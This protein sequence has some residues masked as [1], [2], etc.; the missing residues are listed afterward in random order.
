MVNQLA[1][2]N[3]FPNNNDPDATC[4]SWKLGKILNTRCNGKVDASTD[5]Y[6]GTTDLG[7]ITF[8]PSYTADDFHRG[9]L[10][11]TRPIHTSFGNILCIFPFRYLILTS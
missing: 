4:V 2:D 5:Y 1:W 6:S 10:C 3:G 11:E 9:Y 8:S 7:V